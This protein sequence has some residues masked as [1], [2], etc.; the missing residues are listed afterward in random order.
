MTT[1]RFTVGT[2][3]AS[4]LA[5][6]TAVVA[7]VCGAL[8]TIPI[9]PVLQALLLLVLVLVGVGSAVM[10]WVDLPPA[11][12]V[13]AVLGISVTSVICLAVAMAWMDIWYPVPACLLFSAGV[14]CSGYLRRRS[15]RRLSVTAV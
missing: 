6:N 14:A 13:A 11:P 4:E 7:G 12:M 15:L 3:F 10:C 8:S 9:A 5:A 1:Y 2:R